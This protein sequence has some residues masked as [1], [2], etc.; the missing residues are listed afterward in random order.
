MGRQV[1]IADMNPIFMNVSG[2]EKELNVSLS[3]AL[4]KK[5]SPNH[6]GRGQNALFCDGSVVFVKGRTVD[7]SMD[8]IYTIQGRQNYHGIEVPTSEADIFL[9]P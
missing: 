6:G 9:A 3:D 4:M 1:I 2:N 5:N 8:D 7:V